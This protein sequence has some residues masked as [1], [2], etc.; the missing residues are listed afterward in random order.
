MAVKT[1]ATFSVT[2]LRGRDGGIMRNVLWVLLAAACS[3][4]DAQTLSPEVKEFVKIDAPVVALEHVRV[5]DGTGAPARDDQTMVLAKGT[6]ES[7]ASSSSAN[8]PKGGQVL[9]LH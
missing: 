5:I 9:D 6:I 3:L 2:I 7:V 4:A 8:L 1:L